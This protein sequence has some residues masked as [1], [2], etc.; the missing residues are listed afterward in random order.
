VNDASLYHNRA[1]ELAEQAQIAR[2]RGDRTTAA[3]LT[4]EAFEQERQAALALSDIDIEPT[5][6]VLHRSAAALALDSGENREAEK[7]VSAALAGNPP[8][9]VAEELRDLLEQVH[10]HRHL[11]V[12]GVVLQPDEFQLSLAGGLI[13]LG[14]AQSDEFVDRVRDIETLLYRTAERTLQ[15]PYRDRGRRRDDLRRGLELYISAPRAASFAVTFRVGSYEQLQLPGLDF[16]Q[17]VVDEVLDCL[18]L[19]AESNTTQLRRRIADESYYRNFVALTRRIAPD[20]ERVRAVGL[21]AVRTS[22]ARSVL[23]SRKRSE[24]PPDEEATARL[25]ELRTSE[26]VV[27]RGVL[28]MSDSRDEQRGLIELIGTQGAHHTVQVPLGM[29][30]DIVRPMYEDEVIVTGQRTGDIITLISIDR[31]DDATPDTTA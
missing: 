23:L 31:A 1:M 21:T 11:A 9:D 29:M 3:T 4:R 10:F 17:S 2:L 5:R 30:R 19:L 7:L 26:S 18:T 25:P 8:A 20:G 6:S 14:I 15:R 24:L 13:G 27:V 16:G 22:G 28:K 12:R